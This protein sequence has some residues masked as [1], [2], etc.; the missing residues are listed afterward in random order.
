[1]AVIA[2]SSAGRRALEAI[3]ARPRESRH[4]RRAQARLWLA[5]GERPTAVAQ[6]L[7]GHRHTSYAWAKR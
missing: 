5:E 7:R 3:V 1:M 6:R 4:C 2:F